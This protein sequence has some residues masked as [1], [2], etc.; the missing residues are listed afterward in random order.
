MM[1]ATS[2]NLNINLAGRTVRIALE[3]WG[4]EASE[5]WLLLP[6]LSTVSSRSEW[7]D[8]AKN[9]NKGVQLISFDW[10]GFGDSD[11]PPITYNQETLQT[12]LTAVL[13]H[14]GNSG[15]NKIKLIAAG[16]SASI[17][18]SLAE[19]R[20]QQWIQL[21]L[22]APTWRGPLPTMTGWK[23][24]RFHWLRQ[25]VSL[26]LIGSILYRLN[27]SRAVLR[28]ML[29]R[30]VWVNPEM[31]SPK[32]IQ[33]QQRLSRRRG[34][35]FAS[36]SFVSGGFDPATQS[37]WWLDK[38]EQ[39]HCPLHV[40]LAEEAPPRSKAEMKELAC[41]ADQVSVIKGRLGL[42]QEFGAELAA[43]ISHEKTLN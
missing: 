34:A 26:P 15:P 20:S 29:R 42:H 22:V 38:A 35:R 2:E 37:D 11:R 17:A 7:N 10:P 6:A 1:T 30:H 5:A 8:F 40:V 3:R 43:L 23:P 25:L 28:L 13:N 16:H 31:L 24:E 32:Q 14:L 4:S 19:E 36:V 41:K 21:T 39:L 33:D 18:L 27:T 9:I 12:A